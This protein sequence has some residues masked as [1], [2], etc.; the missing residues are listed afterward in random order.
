MKAASLFGDF[1]K[2]DKLSKQLGK[3]RVSAFLG[4]LSK[5]LGED[6]L[7]LTREGFDTSEA[8]SGARWRRLKADKSRRPLFKT[9]LL[10]AS[11]RVKAFAQKVEVFSYSPLAQIHQLGTEKITARP[12]LPRRKLSPKWHIRL[13]RTFWRHIRRLVAK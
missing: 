1:G 13:E 9:G 7:E 2:L 10:K 11:F 5:D 3:D 12:I 6:L 4:A 8:P